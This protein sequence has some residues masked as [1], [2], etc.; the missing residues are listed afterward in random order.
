[1]TTDPRAFLKSLYD[2]AVAAAD[3][4]EVIGTYLPAPVKGR[5]VVVGA[6][7]ASAAMAAAFED[8]WTAKGYGPVE[9]LVVTRYGHGHSTR[10]IEIVEA[11]H[12]VPDEK[13]AATAGR[14]FDLVKDL[15]PDDQVVA[16]ISGGGSSLLSLPPDVIGKEAKRAVNKIL[17]ASGASIHEMNCVRKHL[18]LIKGGR[19]ARAAHPARVVSLVLSDIP[20]DDPALVASGPTIPDGTTRAD[21][22]AIVERYGMDLPP[23]ARA[24]LDS[25]EAEAPKPTDPDFAGDSHHVIA[26]AQM[27]LDA[28][29][30]KVR[31]AGLT[32]Y[33]LSDSIEGEARDVG[34]VHAAL[35]RQ[36]V[37]KGQP[38]AR[39][40]V[41][42][43]GGE[44]TVTVRAKGR[45]GRN[46]EFLLAFAIG[47]CGVPGVTAIAA[48]T[49]GIDGSEDNAG[50]FCDTTSSDRLFASGTNPKAFL[51][52]NDAYT[53]FM[54]LG[55]LLVTGPTRTNVNDFRAILIE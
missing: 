53:A 9:G 14:I 26:A 40:C 37:A 32:P 33:I 34:E 11:A 15:G 13:G 42:L 10:F 6:G 28:A 24:W 16:L 44:T 19:L 30:A 51:A 20:G 55:D 8:A 18:S 21:A 25:P 52:G 35:V 31:E 4:A 50:A 17:L 47:I 45:G 39:P 54:T 12:P 1:M 5:T 43:S 48:D 29:A 27:S 22:L 49:D 38:F 2:A 3:P 7:K 41:I 36:V 46:A 23:A